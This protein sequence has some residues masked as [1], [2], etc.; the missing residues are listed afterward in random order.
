MKLKIS[1]WEL[2]TEQS[3]FLDFFEEN[4]TR[5]NTRCRET[6][7]LGDFNISL[8]ENAKYVFNKTFSNNK[9]LNSFTKKYLE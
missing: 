1:Q 9:N 5:L 3:N 8:F 6:Y 2:F 7:F 4:L